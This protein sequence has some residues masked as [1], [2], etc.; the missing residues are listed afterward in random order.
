MNTQSAKRELERRESAPCANEG[1]TRRA[2]TGE[3][4]CETC[5]L[6]RSLFQRDLRAVR[7]PTDAR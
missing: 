7:R 4:Y 1:C 2:Q 5:E 6:D 3:R